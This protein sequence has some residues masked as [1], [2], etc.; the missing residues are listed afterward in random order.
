[1]WVGKAQV[2]SAPVLTL[3]SSLFVAVVCILLAFRDEWAE[4][5]IGDSRSFSAGGEPRNR[6]LINNNEGDCDEIPMENIESTWEYA[7]GKRLTVAATGMMVYQN[8]NKLFE[9]YEPANVCPIFCVIPAFRWL[10]NLFNQFGGSPTKRFSLFSGTKGAAGIAALMLVKQEYIESLDDKVSDYIDEWKDDPD[11]VDITIRELLTLSSGISGSFFP[12]KS[13]QSSIEA[14]F[15]EKQWSYSV[16]PFVIFGHI[17]QLTTGRSGWQ[18]LDD[19]VFS[20]LDME[21][22]IGS[23]GTSGVTNFFAAGAG[24]YGPIIL[25]SSSTDTIILA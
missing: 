14:P 17:I 1:M 3:F 24:A 6:V 23:F 11:K 13:L 8:G 4:Y 10:W 15:D 5:P 19:E 12:F 22:P 16:E 25:V 9:E 2:P 7:S 20:V 21:F 18:Y